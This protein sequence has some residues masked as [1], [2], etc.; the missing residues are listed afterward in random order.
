MLYALYKFAICG[1][2]T[3]EGSV[4]ATV[5]YIQ[6][7]IL[8]LPSLINYTCVRSDKE[9]SENCSQSFE[10]LKTKTLTTL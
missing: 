7:L 1:K 4:V 9:A 3:K 5:R 6:S 10:S 2:R 8:D